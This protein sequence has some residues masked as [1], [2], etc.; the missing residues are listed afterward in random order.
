MLRSRRP[1]GW[2]LTPN[3]SRHELPLTVYGDVLNI[4]DPQGGA[5]RPTPHTA[6][7]G[8]NPA[9]QDRLFV[10]RYFRIGARV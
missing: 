2:T 9:W 10:G 1:S 5:R 7:N 8:F 4:F 6:S 3:T